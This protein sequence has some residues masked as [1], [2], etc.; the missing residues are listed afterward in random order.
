MVSTTVP[1]DRIGELLVREGLITQEQLSRA[2]ADAR[3]NNTRV[4]F[5]LIK[6]GFIAEEDLTRML[7]R[8]YRVP[9][10]D[11][12]RVQLDQ[13][14]IRLVPTDL[15]VKHLVLPLRRVG[16]TLTVAMANPA[17]ARSPRFRITDAGRKRF[18]AMKAKERALLRRS[19]VPATASEMAAA[20]D[21]LRRVR[22][23]FESLAP[24][25]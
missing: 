15:A 3:Q 6:L 9:A 16:R 5:S 20:A 2:L 13:K 21:V 4:G 11:L 19:P 24:S 17:H 18:E 25:R 22:E 10:I 8:Q 1:T 23:H 12:N 7:A 14:I